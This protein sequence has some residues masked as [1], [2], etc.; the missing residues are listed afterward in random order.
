MQNSTLLRLTNGE[1]STASRDEIDFNFDLTLDDEMH[2][3]EEHH[4]L[5]RRSDRNSHTPFDERS[6]SIGNGSD[7]DF[8]AE[9]ATESFDERDS[10]DMDDDNDDDDGD[11]EFDLMVTRGRAKRQT[12]KSA[13][14]TRKPTKKE[15]AATKKSSVTTCQ[16]RTTR[17]ASVRF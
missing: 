7:A 11:D 16:N 6:S 1:S 14:K 3:E 15:K 17:A 10:T 13:P 9:E 5:L 12:D 2:I 4:M 8:M